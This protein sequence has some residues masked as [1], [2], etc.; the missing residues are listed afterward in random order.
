[1]WRKSCM[2]TL[3]QLKVYKTLKG[4]LPQK[5]EFGIKPHILS[6]GKSYT[7][8][9]VCTLFSHNIKYKGF[10][11]VV[12]SVIGFRKTFQARNRYGFVLF[13][14]RDIHS[15]CEMQNQAINFRNC[16]RQL[17]VKLKEKHYCLLACNEHSVHIFIIC[18]FS[19]CV[20][21]NVLK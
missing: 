16:K 6:H 8:L 17:G 5:G 7:L 13:W 10:M 11:N 1:M 9:S 14:R 21:I 20:A 4:Y 3:K 19:F 18:T 15:L 12:Q 2:I